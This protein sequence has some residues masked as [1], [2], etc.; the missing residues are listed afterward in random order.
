MGRI[1]R[2]L[3]FIPVGFLLVGILQA[4]PPFAV[5]WAHSYRPEFS[6]LT[7]ILAIIVVSILG[8]VG[9]FWLLGVWATPMLSC[10]IIAPH[11]Q[12]AA[13]I[14]GTL[15]CLHQG[16]FLLGLLSRARWGL[17]I[18]HFIFCAIVVVGVVSAYKGD[19]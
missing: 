18:Y 16:A 17:A 1:I 13:V 5:M 8:T 9:W 19:D 3:V 7:I 12:V 4:L 6:F 15:F 11:P 14:F 2:W 10:R